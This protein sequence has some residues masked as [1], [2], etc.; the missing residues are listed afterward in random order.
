MP[1]RTPLDLYLNEMGDIYDAEQRIT[2]IL[3]TLASEATDTQA[4]SAYQAHLNET[5]QQIQNLEQCFQLLG[6]QPTRQLCAAVVGLKQEH[7]AFLQQQ[8][9]EQVLGLFDLD[10]A[11]KTEAYEIASYQSLV[12]QS[13]LLG[14]Q[15]CAQLLQQNLQQEQAM[16]QRVTQL[17]QQLG[18]QAVSQMP[19]G[20]MGQVGGS[21][22][23]PIV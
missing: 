19:A 23:Q 17:S 10:A 22:Q 21:P 11:A 5:Q 2:Q 18:R 1:L 3:P 20:Q 6:T 12:E 9:S 14:Q 7:D 15:R 13:K 4:K 8:P 16:L